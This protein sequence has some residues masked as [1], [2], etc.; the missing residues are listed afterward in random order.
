MLFAPFDD[1]GRYELR[2]N[3]EQ[4]PN[5]VPE[6]GDKS[7]VVETAMDSLRLLDYF[8]A[9]ADDEVVNAGAIAQELGWPRAVVLHYLTFLLVGRFLV[10]D[11]SRE[12]V[13]AIGR[14]RP[15]INRWLR[16]RGHSM[17]WW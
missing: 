1:E 15:E 17:P 9:H 10:C 13:K 3:P 16:D 7:W 2:L 8:T 4:Q 14:M 5:Y 12:L 11:Q 6:P